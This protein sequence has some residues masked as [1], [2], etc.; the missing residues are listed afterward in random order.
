MLPTYPLHQFHYSYPAQ[1]TLEDCLA[2][3]FW[4]ERE[5]CQTQTHN[6]FSSGKN[7]FHMEKN[8]F[9][10]EKNPKTINNNGATTT[11]KPQQ[12][13][14]EI[15][16][17]IDKNLASYLE[18]ISLTKRAKKHR[19]SP[20]RRRVKRYPI[21]L[22][23]NQRRIRRKPEECKQQKTYC[24]P[25]AGCQ[26]SYISKCSMHLHIKNRHSWNGHLKP[27]E[28]LPIISRGVRKGVNIYQV[29]KNVV[30]LGPEVGGNTFLKL[31]NVTN[32]KTLFYYGNQAIQSNQN[33]KVCV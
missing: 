10:S 28:E 29:F 9:P 4:P 25:Y 22:D 5:K 30:V 11:I 1:H 3:Y 16:A 21:N 2:S 13:T 31:G 12:K 6:T 15:C 24:C 18:E 7:N 26:K 32:S 19:G 27:G 8:N 33:L 14:S 20:K 23:P 17:A